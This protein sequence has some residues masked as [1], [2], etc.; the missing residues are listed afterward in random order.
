MIKIRRVKPN[1]WAA[2]K[3]VVY[4]VAHT[5]FK[6]PLPLEESIA[7]H[8]ARHELK[9][10]DDIQKNY[11][12]NGGVFLVTTND[13]QV[14][15]TGALRKLEDGICELKRLWLLTEYQGMG[16]GYRMLQELLS[17]ARAKG[18]QRIRLETDYEVQRQAY[19]FYKQVGFY[20]IPR[21]TDEN[22]D[23][24]MEMVL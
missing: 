19:N 3:R 4:C 13:D 14:I 21:Y 10:M 23:V 20:D 24:A 7:Y 1:E 17:I 22:D 16:L 18:Y 12:N 11:F 9:D 6:D 8:E 2:A 5:L 15:G